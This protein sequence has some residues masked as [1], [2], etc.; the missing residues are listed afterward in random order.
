MHYRMSTSTC[1]HSEQSSEPCTD[2][3]IHLAFSRLDGDQEA[4]STTVVTVRGKSHKLG[5]FLV[6]HKDAG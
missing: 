1:H 5:L 4:L 6:D 3:V 2:L